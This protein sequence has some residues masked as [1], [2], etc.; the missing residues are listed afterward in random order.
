MTRI[1]VLAVAMI[2]SVGGCESTAILE[3]ILQ[4]T[5]NQGGLS[6]STIARGMREALSVGPGRVVDT[7]GTSGG[8]ADS[9]FH[10]PLPDKLQDARDVA[11][12]FGLQ[13][14][15]DTLE[16]KMNE[17]A[18]AA[19]PQA[20][21]L[22]INAI[23]AMSFEDVM[24]IYKGADDAATQYLRRSTQSQIATS[25][26]PVIDQHLNSVGAVRTFSDLATRYNALPLV[27]PIDADL[28][29]HVSGYAMDAIFTQL[30]AEEAAIRNEPLK[31]T[32]ALLKRLFD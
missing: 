20:G 10:I 13:K 15:F 29:G 2:L 4:S 8:I 23:T 30:A 18:E 32:T 6:S 25:M 31:R 28:T 26:R 27:K 14:P 24:S 16:A 5:E 22:F 1:R 3:D 17:A 21:D 11:G 9:V 7:L 19:I 12:R